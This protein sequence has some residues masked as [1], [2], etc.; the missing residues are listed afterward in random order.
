MN[1]RA[2]GGRTV[3]AMV[4][5]ALAG[6]AMMLA[7]CSSD[8]T[9]SDRGAS[10]AR[11]F[12]SAAARAEAFPIDAAA[13]ARL[14][15]RWDWTGF[16]TLGPGE[17]LERVDVYPDIIVAQETGSGVSVL[18]AAN[19]SQRWSSTLTSPLTKF[20]GNVRYAD[21]AAGDVLLASSESEVFWL[22]VATGTLV[23]RQPLD[24]VV[25][26]RPLIV[27][28]TA[29]YGTPSG[30]IF[31]HWLARG[32]KTWGFGTPAAVEQ[33][34][35]PIAPGIVCAINQAG[36]VILLGERGGLQSRAEI[37]GAPGAPPAVGNGMIFIAS[38]DQSLYAYSANG[39]QAWRLRTNAPLRDRPVFHDGVLYCTIPERGLSAFDAATGRE[40]WSNKTIGGHVHGMRRGRLLVH[41]G[42][43]VATLDLKNGATVE[44]IQVQGLSELMSDTFVDGPLYAA[45]T[46]GVIAKFLPR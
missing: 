22:A 19:G 46:S 39:T 12:S 5:A 7:A 6:S 16:P 42:Q 2:T 26:T 35:L 31:A 36:Q 23:N 24:K 13:W 14:G 8:G 40:L 21:P 10:S 34:I 33:D 11:T 18:E 17:T 29:V 44:S 25:N 27:G 38:V 37:F 28:D 43:T 41:D 45:S 3:R 1:G 30:E 20:V 4:L 9:S 15:Y 32:L